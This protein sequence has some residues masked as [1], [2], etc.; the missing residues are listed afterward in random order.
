MKQKTKNS[1]SGIREERKMNEE[2]RETLRNRNRKK[3]KLNES[4]SEEN[5]SEFPKK[6][7]RG[8]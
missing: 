7:R 4:I 1:E 3:R 6:E 8:G 2:L 5:T